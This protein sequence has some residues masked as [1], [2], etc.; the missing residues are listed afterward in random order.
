MNASR[1]KVGTV[2]ALAVT[3]V[4]ALPRSLRGQEFSADVVNTPAR[5]SNTTRVYVGATKMRLQ[6]FDNGQP[7]V[8]MIWD[9]A[10]KTTTL[11][12]DKNHS[13]IAGN[14]PI[15]AAMLNR[16]GAPTLVRIFKPTN[17]SDPC[18]DWNAAVLPY[19]DSTKPPPHFTCQAAGLD[20]VDGRPAKKWSVVTT[21]GSK[22]E[23]GYAWIDSKLHV[24][25]KSKDSTGT[26]ELKNVKEGSQPDAVFQVPVGYHPVDATA[27][28]AQLKGGSSAIAGMFGAAA[29][30]VGTDAANEAAN[31]A[32]QKASDA[33]KKKIKSAFHFP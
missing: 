26:V 19:Q 29:K 31:D 14:S 24:V 8:S 3:L 9:G 32:K 13:Y 10:Q 17:A 2:I 30:D 33:L 11:V 12:M 15:L 28:L 27:L 1:Q 23:A 4:S 16:S 21:Q 20:M 6:V 25:S 7:E 18:T 5:G 22:K